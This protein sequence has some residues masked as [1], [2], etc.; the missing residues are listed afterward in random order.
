MAEGYGALYAALRQR[1]AEG[2]DSVAISD[3]GAM[4]RGLQC[5]RPIPGGRCFLKVPQAALLTAAKVAGHP[6][7]GPA[8]VGLGDSLQL[9]L[10]LLYL[11]QEDP[12]GFTEDDRFFL[13]YI[14]SLPTTAQGSYG[15]DLEAQDKVR[16]TFEVLRQSVIEP[17]SP[18]VFR[19]VTRYT[20]PDF[21]LAY[22]NVMSRSMQFDDLLVMVPLADMLNHLPSPQ[23]SR[24]HLYATSDQAV[25]IYARY[26]YEVGEQVTINYGRDLP[27]AVLHY[28]LPI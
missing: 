16:E 17:N 4:G 1:G 21:L 6:V 20:F 13:L 26:D 14:G 9:S 18:T 22:S 27:D 3:Y 5:V 15:S 23:N 24:Y 10:Y 7:L 19:N 11:Q 12:A 28:G 2:L 8:V 25:Y